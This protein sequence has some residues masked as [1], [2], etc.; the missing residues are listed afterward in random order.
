MEAYAEEYAGNRRSSWG[1][2]RPHK[3]ANAARHYG[4]PPVNTHNA[5]GDCK[6]TL[7][8]VQAMVRATDTRW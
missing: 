5:L 8:V 1:R 7:A 6:L 4:I 3:L 2:P